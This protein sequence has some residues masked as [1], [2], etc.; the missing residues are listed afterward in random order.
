MADF[1]ITSTTP[2]VASATTPPASRPADNGRDRSDDRVKFDDHLKRADRPSDSPAAKRA[3]SRDDASS[4]T[5]SDDSNSASSDAAPAASQDAHVD[6]KPATDKPDRH[7]RAGAKKDPNDD[8]HKEQPTSDA[9]S[10]ATATVV[11]VE[12]AAA[13]PVDEVTIAA[14]E[15]AEPTNQTPAATTDTAGTTQKNVAVQQAATPVTIAT[16]T[17]GKVSPKATTTDEVKAEVAEEAQPTA[18][19]ATSAK[20]LPRFAPASLQTLKDTLA[21]NQRTAQ[22][23][24]AANSTNTTQS[25]AVN[26]AATAQAAA[27]GAQPVVTIVSA[28]HSLPGE[29]V[30]THEPE[31]T[32]T[33]VLSDQ[34]QV[35][36]VTVSVQTALVTTDIT[37]S[38]P[39]DA[40]TDATSDAKRAD[41]HKD[42]ITPTD[43]TPKTPP[44]A[45]NDGPASNRFQINLPGHG[46]LRSDGVSEVDRV[47][48]VQRVARAFRAADED[49]GQ[50]RLRLNPPELGALKL[51]ITM[52]AGVMTAKLETETPAAKSMLLDNLPAL[53]ERLAEQNIKVE[54]F[55]VD[56][57][58]RQPGG[59]PDASPDNTGRGARPP[60]AFAG[61]GVSDDSTEGVPLGGRV[62]VDSG[63]LNVVI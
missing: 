51:E 8:R 30:D 57:M 37:S 13:T 52:K 4:K 44:A 26:S 45:S 19:N 35:A 31:K 49:G 43:P 17:D 42:P 58:D 33:S 25:P 5:D 6:R 32:S 40:T 11:T 47:R 38:A 10:Q 21:A 53:R 28:T 36:A 61:A 29:T 41:T 63:Q 60:R 59:M 20:P 46:E 54:K 34:V 14:Q 56:V 12:Q 27:G 7:E 62:F 39:I 3:S 23:A 15:T 2:A 9:G 1:S 50:V 18:E 16:R 24:P 48:F 22:V 55:D